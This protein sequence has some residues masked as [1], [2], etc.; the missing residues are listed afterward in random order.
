MNTIENN[1]MTKKQKHLV[2]ALLTMMFFLGVSASDIYIASLPQMVHDFNATPSSINLTLSIYTVGVAFAVLFVGE[3]SSRY[4]RRLILLLGV[5]CFSCSALLISLIPWLSIIILLRGLQAFGC[6]VIVIVPRLILKDCMDEREQIT[7]NGLML[8]GLIISPAIAPVLG[9][10]LAKYW[11]WRS[12]FMFS[13]ITGIILIIIG[14]FILPE[15]LHQKLD[16]FHPAKHYLQMYLKLATNR[17]F[18]ALTAMYATGVGAYFAF[19]GVSSYLY[20]NHWHISPQSYSLLY[21]WL[22]AAYLAGNQ[23]MQYLNSHRFDPVSIIGVGVYSTSIG[24]VIVLSSWFVSDVKLTMVL[25]TMGV[26][27]MRAAN[28]LINPPTQI[29]IMSHF[30]GNSAQALG[31]NMCVGF[32]VSSIAISLVTIVPSQP[33][34]SLLIV[35]GIFVSICAVAFVFNRKSLRE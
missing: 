12:C 20:I 19:I 11:G 24:T 32:L 16:R 6:A 8:M 35:S 9:A 10:Y 30:D 5:A 14:Y 23:I 7:A 28:A 21:L 17:V 1:N 2:L 25:V 34:A 15:T 26:V 27:F 31:L 13:S 29:R 3:L 4:G 22:S 33:L 18:I